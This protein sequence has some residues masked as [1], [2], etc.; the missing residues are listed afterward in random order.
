MTS[1]ERP[2]PEPILK[3]KRRP[4]PY[5]GRRILEMLWKLSKCLELKG[6]GHPSRTLEGN[7]SFWGLSGNF[8]EFLPG[9]PSRT[10][11]MSHKTHN[12]I[13]TALVE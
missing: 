9:S 5:W 3:K 12:R 8:P 2:S 4:Q 10:G 6:W 11:G 7:S 1:S 13:C